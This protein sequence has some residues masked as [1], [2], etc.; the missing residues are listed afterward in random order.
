MVRGT[1]S[2]T[3][4]SRHVAAMGAPDTGIKGPTLHS[5]LSHYLILE[6]LILTVLAGHS[7]RTAAK[8]VQPQHHKIVGAALAAA[9]RRANLYASRIG[10]AARQA[11]IGGVRH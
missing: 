10:A 4:G 3:D 8:W 7:M 6:F 11:A 1:P 5:R 2:R 9:R